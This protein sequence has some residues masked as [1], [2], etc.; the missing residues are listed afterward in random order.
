MVTWLL[1][2]QTEALA[3]LTRVTA[4][5]SLPPLQPFTG[6]GKLAE[7]YSVE[8]WLEQFEERAELVGCR[9]FIS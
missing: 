9:S 6:E 5:Q 8:Q 7:E 3:A 4:A 2:A 1:H